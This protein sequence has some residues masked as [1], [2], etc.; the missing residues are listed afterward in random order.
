MLLVLLACTAAARAQAAASSDHDVTM[1][2]KTCPWLT[3]GTAAEVLGGD[4]TVTVA[5]NSDEGT[6]RF[7]RGGAA[8]DFLE[9][10]VSAAP[11]RGCPAGSPPLR[12]IGNEAERCG[13]S[14]ARGMTEE[15]ASG[16][17]R[18]VHFTVTISGRGRRSG[19]PSESDDDSLARIAD[20][21]AGNLY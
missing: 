14:E 1:T 21:V 2:A 8:M 18:S 17:V 7:V 16:R 3:M 5:G 12:G 11:L 4:V 13:V 19:H 10:H 9:V 20:E 15:M 6:C